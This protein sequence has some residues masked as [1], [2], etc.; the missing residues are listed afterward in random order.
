MKRPLVSNVDK[1]IIVASTHIPRF[2]TY[3][4]DKF[5]VIAYKHNIEPI[6]CLTKIDKLSFKDKSDLSKYIKYYKKL[7]IKVYKNT[8]IKK[9]IKEIKNNTVA[10]AGQT[11]A[12]KSTLLNRMDKTLNLKTD[13]ISIALGRGKHTTRIVELFPLFG[14]LIADTPGF[15]SL[16]LVSISSEEVRDSFS[17]FG[18]KCKYNSCMHIGEDGCSV[19]K[20]VKNNMIGD[21]R[22]KNYLKLLEEA[23][24]EK[25]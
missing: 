25:K 20:R 10:L 8:Q 23:K 17:E 21:F 2:S 5:L 18:Q 11:G 9:I 16:D 19:I 7:G 1:L 24:E 3:L 4:I 15:S 22:Y 12:G 14:G 13:E 6:I